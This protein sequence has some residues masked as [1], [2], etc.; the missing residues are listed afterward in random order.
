M[1][2]AALLAANL[3][4][5]CTGLGLLPLLGVA[6]SWR[7]LVARSGLA[8]L[9]GILL[10]AI[11]AANLALVHVSFGWIGLG[12]LAALS[13]VVGSLRLRGTERPVYRRPTWTALAGLGAL[14]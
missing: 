7:E 8:Y 9:C 2:V 10:A 12:V 1:R 4:M 11:V 3:L 5:F 13:L 14:A 6:R